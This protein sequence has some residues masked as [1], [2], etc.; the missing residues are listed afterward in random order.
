VLLQA[1]EQV[2]GDGADMAVRT[3]GGHHQAVGHGGLALEVDEDDVLGLVVIQ[4]VQDKLLQRGNA[5]REGGS[6][7]RGRGGLRGL[8]RVGAQRN[9]SCSVT[10]KKALSTGEGSGQ[11]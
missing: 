1:A 10:P 5:L 2:V 8:R 3:P 7:G 6:G 9:N 4:A 11:P